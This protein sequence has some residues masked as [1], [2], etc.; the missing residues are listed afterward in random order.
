RREYALLLQRPR[1][2]DALA[3]EERSRV[4]RRPQRKSPHDVAGSV[5][6]TEQRSAAAGEYGE[7][8]GKACGIDG[9]GEPS[10]DRRSQQRALPLGAKRRPP[11]EQA[12]NYRDDDQ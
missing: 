7:R 9:Y 5:E 1:Q 2:R 3:D 10:E 4:R 8:A 11:V 6:R 12:E